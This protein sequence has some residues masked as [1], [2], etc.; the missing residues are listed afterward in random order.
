MHKSIFYLQF[1]NKKKN[2]YITVIKDY[3]IELND[4]MLIFKSN[5]N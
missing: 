5:N 2:T 4:F 3:R 1:L